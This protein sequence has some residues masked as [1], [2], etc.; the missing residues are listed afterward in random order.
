MQR[1]R[2]QMQ[3]ASANV[4]RMTSKMNASLKALYEVQNVL[5]ERTLSL[6]IVQ[7]RLAEA[8]RTVDTYRNAMVLRETT[9]HDMEEEL[10]LAKDS[11]RTDGGR[12][13]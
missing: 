3:A 8:E 2:Q 4:D 7:Q 5:E 6:E 13:V 11:G 10:S 9:L 12:D 1:L